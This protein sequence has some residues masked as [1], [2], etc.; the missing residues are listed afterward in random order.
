MVRSASK[1]VGRAASA[2]P[3]FFGEVSLEVASRLARGEIEGRWEITST[4]P[5]RC[6]LWLRH[7]AGR[8]IK[9]VAINGKPWPQF[10]AESVTLPAA[11]SGEFRIRFE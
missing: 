7:P 1:P 6:V 2:M 5:R 10:D 9:S 11:S 4:P 8:A 3:T